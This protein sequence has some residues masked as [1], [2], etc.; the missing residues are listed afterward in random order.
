[1]TATMLMLEVGLFLPNV[2][3]RDFLAT[4]LNEQ[5]VVFRGPKK[6]NRGGWHM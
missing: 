6:T 2:H 5:G 3:V 1:M 4:Y